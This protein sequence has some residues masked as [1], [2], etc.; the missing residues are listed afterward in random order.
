MP[1]HGSRSSSHDAFVQALN[2]DMVVAQTGFAN[3]YGFPIEAVVQ[4]YQDQ[5]AIVRNTANGAVLFTWP[6]AQQQADVKQWSVKTDT[7]RD[8]ARA[9]WGSK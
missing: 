7:R 3:R 4:R 8:R 5:G 2:P 9:W 1:H 6:I